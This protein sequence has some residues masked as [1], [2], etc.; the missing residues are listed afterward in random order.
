MEYPFFKAFPTDWE[1]RMRQAGIPPAHRGTVYRLIFFAWQEQ[2]LD[3][4][5]DESYLPRMKMLAQAF[6]MAFCRFK[7]YLD[8]YK[9]ISEQDAE[10]R[11]LPAFLLSQLQNAI[12]AVDAKQKKAAPDTGNGKDAN[13]IQVNLTPAPSQSPTTSEQTCD[14]STADL[15]QTWNRPGTDSEQT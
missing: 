6:G 3:L 14:N 12:A 11:W 9:R 13:H 7:V 10:G 1:I 2:G 4:T 8:Y 15:E 5:D